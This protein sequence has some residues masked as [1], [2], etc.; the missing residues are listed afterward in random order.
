MSQ[1]SGR[2]LGNKKV[3]LCIPED[4]E[5]IRPAA[6]LRQWRSRSRS[7]CRDHA[8]NIEPHATPTS[9]PGRDHANHDR[10]EQ[11]ATPASE[12][13]GDRTYPAK[14]EPYGTS[15]SDFPLLRLRDPYEM[16]RD[17]SY[18]S[19]TSQSYESQDTSSTEHLTD[20]FDPYAD[21]YYHDRQ[22]HEVPSTTSYA[23]DYYESNVHYQDD[24][25]SHNHATE[26]C[27]YDDSR[28]AY[29]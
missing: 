26:P 1:L 28:W 25:R 20:R 23:Y 8:Y 22:P 21:V 11:D 16:Q 19:H 6:S 13:Y 7:P 4:E 9:E 18:T 5:N 12:P 27:R 24:Y 29:N 3:T 14:Y 17:R 10:H 15:A 2:K